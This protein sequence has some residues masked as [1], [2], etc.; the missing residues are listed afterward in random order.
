M[1]I[2]TIYLT[3]RHLLTFYLLLITSLSYS[4][5]QLVDQSDNSP[6]AF[7]HCFIDEGK[8]GTTSNIDGIISVSELKKHINNGNELI[9][10]QHI[11][12]ENLQITLDDLVNK[13]AVYLI[14]RTYLLDEAVVKPQKDGYLVIKAY[15]RNYQTED[16]IFKYFSD[17][18]VEYY[19]P[20]KNKSKIKYKIVEFRNFRN[21]VLIDK[22]KGKYVDVSIYPPSLV[23]LKNSSMIEELQKEKYTF[24]KNTN[25]QDI[26]KSSSKVGYI[27]HDKVKE[28]STIS[29]DKIAPL[30]EK[31]MRVFGYEFRSKESDI[32][33]NYILNEANTF[34]IKDLISIKSYSK[35]SLKNIK[36]DIILENEGISEIFVIENKWLSKEEVKKMNLSTSRYIPESHSYKT[37]YWENL[38][39][40]NIPSISDN[41]N[42]ELGKTL[43]MY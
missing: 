21:Q 32:T 40:Y 3:M 26:F 7:A 25:G 28:Y 1:P 41:V 22:N 43:I 6:V 8:I 24:I 11:G 27:K 12:Y 17:G 5:V 13:K 31:V 39:K 34:D 15:F 36:K 38:D 10:I 23:E 16:G 18:F 19:I 20:D 4:Q 33:E 2:H 29:V 37:N 9:T 35:G 30:K 42:Q 14:P